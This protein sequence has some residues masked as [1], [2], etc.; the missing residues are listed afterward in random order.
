MSRVFI[1]HSSL[2]SR[3]AV[4]VKKWLIGE[5]PGLGDEIFLDLD[6]LTGIRPGQ[7]WKESLQRANSRCEA[8][9]C[10]LSTNWAAS[11]ECRTEYRYAETL[12]KAILVARLEPMPDG[13]L[14]SE[15]QRC[16][17]FAG[18]G[19]V[20]AVTVD[21]EDPVLLDAQGMRRLLNGLRALG[22]GA[23]H[24]AWPPPHDL[25]RAPYRGWAP[26]DEADAAVFFGRDTQ[27][28]RAMD[29]LRGMRASGVQ[30]I[31]VIL[32]PSG[33]GKSSFLRAG[34]LPRVRRD[35][36]QFVPLDIV[37]PERAA[38]TGELGLA[39][40]IHRLRVSLGL[41]APELGNIKAACTA[42][43]VAQIGVWLTE[44]RHAARD[45]IIDGSGEEPGPTLVLP[46]DQGEELF[47]ADAG[48]QAT[49]LLRILAALLRSTADVTPGLLVAVTIRA[50]RYEPLQ[51]ASE[52]AEV[53]SVVFDELKPM[54]VAG[55]AE[56]IAGPARRATVAGRRLRVDPVLVE[57]LL[58]DSAV[59]ADALPLLALTLHRLYHDF[60]GDGDLTVDEYV[61]MGGIQQVVQTEV[62]SLLSADPSKREAELASLRDA[63]IPF[64]ATVN[65]DN[66]Q[67][68]RRMAR[69]SELPAA[70]R[71]LVDAFVEKRLLV[72]DTRDGFAVVEVALESLLRQWRELAGWLRV[73]ARD[74]KA[75][76]DLE[77]A[78]ADWNMT[79]HNPAWLLGGTRL[80]EAEALAARPGFRDRLDPTREFLRAGR[81]A[82]V[83]RLTEERRRHEVELRVAREKQ[84]AAEAL[85][86]AETAAKREAVN[87]AAALRKRS[88]V[89]RR[90]LAVALLLA[91][92]AAAGGVT[93]WIQRDN[94]RDERDRADARTH[95]VIAQRLT[96][97]G[98][99]MLPG[100]RGGG[101][102]RAYKQMLAA[103]LVAPAI[104]KS[105]LYTAVVKLERTLK[106]IETPGAVAAAFS[107][108]GERIAVGNADDTVRLWDTGTGQPVGNSLVGHTDEVWEVAVSSDGS[109]VASTGKDRTL[110]IWDAATGQ[111]LCE[112]IHQQADVW[113]LA[114]S[115]DGTRI[116]SGGADNAV[117]VWDASTGRPVGSPL[118]GHTAPVY[119]AVFSNDGLRVASGGADNT[120]W[121]WDVETGRVVGRPLAAHAGA[122]RTVA[123]SPDGARIASG[124]DDFGV[125]LWDVETGQQVAEPLAGHTGPL[126]S[127]AFSTDGNR[128]V[129]GSDDNTVRVWDV[130]SGESVGDPLV[131]H[132]SFLYGVAFSP[133]GR[134]V[135]S[136]G[137]DD[138]VRVWDAVTRVP[139]IEQHDPVNSQYDPLN[140]LAFSPDGTRIVTGG[141]DG[142][143]RVWDAVTGDPVS[144]PLIGHGGNVLS[145]AFSPDGTRIVSGGADGAVRVWDAGDGE[146]VGNPLVGHT[147]T[148]WSVA[149]SP[150]GTRIASGGAD[151]AVQLWDADALTP[152]G[153]PLTGHGNSASGSNAV[154]GVAFSPDGTRIVSGGAD[155]TVRVW[156]ADS[157]RPLGDPLVGHRFAVF[158]VAFSP[159]GTRIISSSADN[160]IRVWDAA[161]GQMVGQLTGHQQPVNSVAFSRDGTRIVSGG[162]DN[163]VRLWD[164]G[165][166]QPL[167]QPMAGHE[168]VVWGVAFSPDGN[169][170][171]STSL[172][173]TVR[174]W[175]VY[176]GTAELCAKLTSNM[177]REQW[178][179][180]VS[181][182]IAYM[183]VCQG[184]PIPGDDGAG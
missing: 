138:T 135:L 36:R 123:F 61:A 90:V 104:D 182:D 95:E 50:D 113:S 112:P 79:D 72:K 124:S 26:L 156:D 2:D 31:L 175:P 142:A 91:V 12:N 170:I 88:V 4:A 24:F 6:P 172:D 106:I 151:N 22:I 184:L 98:E 74:L 128:I 117:R 56:V 30:S 5:E 55:Y 127:V 111:V 19:P 161:T 143:A 173:G 134:R 83:Q 150:D 162:S 69:Y 166:L 178:R 145:V 73:E 32:G 27:I 77:R 126:S 131:G 57:R 118:S 76:D 94:A 64:L 180:W 169:R 49:V 99:L 15:W 181:E 3:H 66:E 119:S 85:V 109:R 116:V 115:R 11:S 75:A 70:S 68:L 108:D 183:R 164:T 81:A 52:L 60:G 82:E 9:I 144:R 149:F 67:P 141:A 33:C 174:L 86:A 157:R 23:G 100:A 179:Q 121:V 120:V 62:D 89:M 167:G 132:Q 114:F 153:D 1:S 47:G 146:P 93:A 102:V 159:D 38:L 7:R 110:R 139:V 63:F 53:Q 28:V 177:S 152:T 107:A 65:R 20:T 25:D 133:D 29:E 125:H 97:E 158:S 58:A 41:G 18:S 148:V 96:S 78:A 10:L 54:P 129:S 34:L 163:T 51:T 105:A 43:E 21:D 37:R 176:T 160:T 17:V 45:R 122:V 80:A 84:E 42:G 155:G 92:L 40:A 165:T 48:P 39:N 59:G 136:S 154:F 87:H 103:Q 46:L 35:D 16:D 140:S 8:V 13:D 71:P 101:D 147:G 171:A 130:N 14:T 168:D 137:A 44:A